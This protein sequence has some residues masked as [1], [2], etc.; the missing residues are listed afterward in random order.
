M[1]FYLVTFTFLAATG[2]PCVVNQLK[3]IDNGACFALGEFL[4]IYAY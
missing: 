1:T 2:F 4:L 3:T